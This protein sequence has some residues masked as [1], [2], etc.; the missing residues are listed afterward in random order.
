M[1]VVEILGIRRAV[2][3][4]LVPEAG[5]GDFVLVHAGYGIEVISE[6][7]AQETLELIAE[8]PELIAND[9]AGG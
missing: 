2:A 7:M 1:A 3:C 8:F 5:V 4:D 9:S 6:Q